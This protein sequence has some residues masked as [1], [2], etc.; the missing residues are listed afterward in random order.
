VLSVLPST[1]TASQG[2]R[3]ERGS[4]TPGR[5]STTDQPRSKV[6]RRHDATTT[7]RRRSP[8]HQAELHHGLARGQFLSG[9]RLQWPR[10]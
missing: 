1:T 5:A 7:R 4:A 8:F 3:P 2:L 6:V 9:P 10:G